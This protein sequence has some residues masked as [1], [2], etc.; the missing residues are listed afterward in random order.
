MFPH[1]ECYT[2]GAAAWKP[3]TSCCQMI[4]GKAL[5]WPF[6]RLLAHTP[7]TTRQLNC[8]LPCVW[9]SS[10]S[11]TFFSARMK[12]ETKADK[13]RVLAEAEAFNPLLWTIAV[14]ADDM[15][16][17][18]NCGDFLYFWAFIM[19]LCNHFGLMRLCH[20]PYTFTLQNCSMFSTFIQW[21]SIPLTRRSQY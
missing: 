18:V 17:Y 19:I 21:D 8:V 15:C 3:G 14:A 16:K 20:M 7:H 13:Q 9:Y 12:D 5:F 11:C 10:K 4:C 2:A 1:H 6:Y